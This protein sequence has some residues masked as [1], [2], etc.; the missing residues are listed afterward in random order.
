MRSVN[1]EEH[2]LDIDRT[3]EILTGPWY[4]SKMACFHF[5]GRY[6]IDSS[7]TRKGENA[8]PA[9]NLDFGLGK[10][11]ICVQYK[12]PIKAPKNDENQINISNSQST[13][14]LA[15]ETKSKLVLFS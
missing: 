15:I 7:I 2:K 11:K 10:K 9:M 1:I 13:I 8:R 4:I 14:K 5:D 12:S 3:L 6:K